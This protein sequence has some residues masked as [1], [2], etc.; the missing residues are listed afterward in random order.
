MD[1]CCQ[2]GDLKK[3]GTNGWA[4]NKKETW[5]LIT[6]GRCAGERFPTQ[7]RTTISNLNEASLELTL[8]KKGNNKVV[9]S[10][11]K[12]PREYICQIWY[13]GVSWHRHDSALGLMEF[14]GLP[15]CHPRR[16]AIPPPA[17]SHRT[18]PASPNLPRPLCVAHCVRP[19]R[20]LYAIGC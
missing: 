7:A 10:C 3:A 1:V 12:A 4:R 8:T 19:K 5:P 2:T 9:V 20:S 18:P 14:L 17:R 13:P 11:K 6:L 16:M 15:L